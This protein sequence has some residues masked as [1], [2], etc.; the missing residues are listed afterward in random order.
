MIYDL[1]F[2]IARWGGWLC[3]NSLPNFP[4]FT[5]PIK[6]KNNIQ[7]YQWPKL[8]TTT[9]NITSTIGRKKTR[10]YP[11]KTHNTYTF[12]KLTKTH[13][14]AYSLF[15]AT[16]WNSWKNWH[17][18]VYIRVQRRRLSFFDA[19]LKIL[20]EIIAGSWPFIVGIYTYPDHEVCSLSLAHFWMKSLS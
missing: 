8:S 5:F 10:K 4:L 16:C 14:Q 2:M 3:R 17:S 1:W 7:Q 11:L 9:T 20:Y 18:N 19:L 13:F 6:K 15:C 12:H